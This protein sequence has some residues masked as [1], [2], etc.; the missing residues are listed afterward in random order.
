MRL[1]QDLV[2]PGKAKE[3]LFVGDYIS[4]KEA[5]HIGLVNKAVPLEHLMEAALAMAEKIAANSSFSLKMIKK[6]LH[7]AA[8]EASLE[9]VMAYEVEACLACVSTQ[10]RSQ[11]LKDFENRKKK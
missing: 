9:A 5:E 2:G 11:S 7:L 6:G 3:L 4:G 1:V 10:E 8:G